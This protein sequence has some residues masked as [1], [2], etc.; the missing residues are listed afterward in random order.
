[1]KRSSLMITAAPTVTARLPGGFN[2]IKDRQQPVASDGTITQKMAEGKHHV[3]GLLTSYIKFSDIGRAFH[4]V[5]HPT[6]QQRTWSFFLT[7]RNKEERQHERKR[8]V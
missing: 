8:L 2:V 1:M 7:K 5:D 4:L 6:R 3:E